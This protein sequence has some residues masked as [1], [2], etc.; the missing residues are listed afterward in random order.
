MQGTQRRDRVG[1]LVWVMLVVAAGLAVGAVLALTVP[2][3]PP[4][5]HGPGA[6]PAPPQEP[7]RA[8]TLFSTL[9]VALLLAL[10]V[11]YA[12][13]YGQTRARFAAG[14]LVVLGA[15]LV[16]SLASSPAVIGGLGVAPGNLGP[17]FLLSAVF[18]SIALAV[19]LYLSLE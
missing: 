5:G 12:R 3:P 7:V 4:P 14:L 17:F 13:T 18:E 9:V 19:F 2:V 8:A 15:L 11:V 16:Q 6:P 1:P 10:L